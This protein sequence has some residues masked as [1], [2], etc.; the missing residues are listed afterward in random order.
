M[1]SED[2]AL[3]NKQTCV[4]VVRV[5]Q[6]VPGLTS[7]V[8]YQLFRMDGG[9]ITAVLVVVRGDV[10]IGAVGYSNASWLVVLGKPPATSEHTARL[11][12]P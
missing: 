12:W 9:A 2:N 8:L 1:C 11:S 4:E 7:L 10:S 5:L 6:L 3:G